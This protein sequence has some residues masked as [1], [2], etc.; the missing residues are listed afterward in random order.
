MEIRPVEA[1]LFHADGQW[2]ANSRF[3]AIL[4]KDLKW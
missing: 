2:E 1:S 4:W 3:F